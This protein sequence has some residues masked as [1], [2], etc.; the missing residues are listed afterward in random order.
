[1]KRLVAGACAP[2]N[3][4][5]LVD[6][7][8]FTESDFEAEVV[9]ALCCLFPQYRCG[10][11]SGSFD[12]D[13]ERRVADLALLHE[14]FSHWFVVE[15][16]LAG[17]SWE[18]H[19]LPQLRCFRY[20]DPCSTCVSSLLRAFPRLG[21]DQ[22]RYI[23]EFVPR[24]VAVVVNMPANSWLPGLAALDVQHLLVSVYRSADG[25]TAH[26]VQGRLVARKEDLGFA[27]Y[28]EQ[29]GC[30]R[31]PDR[32]SLQPGILAIRD[33]F[34]STADWIVR[35][36]SGAAWISKISGRPL[37]PHNAY[38]Q[39]IRSWTGEISLFVRS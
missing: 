24:Y 32:G 35:V 39:L 6:P 27:R 1:M 7:T 16:E 26:E 2:S 3:V 34:G 19:V 9:K 22:A 10:V 13:G 33:Q 28:S 20:G 11:F 14:S 18:H 25:R 30:L 4:F 29:D 36:Q 15:V 23:V 17:H 8:G 12:L 5:E 21:E 38:V 37:I 31:M